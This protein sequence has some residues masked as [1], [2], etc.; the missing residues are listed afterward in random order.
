MAATGLGPEGHNRLVLP[1]QSLRLMGSWLVSITRLI[2][3]QTSWVQAHCPWTEPL[4][5][6]TENFFSIK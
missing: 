2:T 3:E 4:Y 1:Y 6:V 5:E